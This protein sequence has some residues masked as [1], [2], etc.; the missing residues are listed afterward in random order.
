MS[1]SNAKKIFD[2]FFQNLKEFGDKLSKE[3]V[4]VA[5]ESLQI[6]FDDLKLMKKAAVEKKKEAERKQ[7][8]EDE[9]REKEEKIRK[10]NE[11]IK[12]VTCMDLPLDWNNPYNADERASGIYIESI[13]DALVKSLTTLGR[14]DIEFIASV[15]SSD[16]K[17]VITTLRGSIY[18]N[19]LTWNECFYHGWETSEEYLSGNLMEKLRVAKKANKKYNGYFKN[20][21]KAI[22]SVLPP[23]VATDDIYI[24]LGSPWVPSD[25]IDDF[26][27]HLFGEN[28]KYW[29]NSDRMKDYLSVKH[30]ELTGTWE[31]P[32][33]TR[34]GHGVTDTESYGTSRLE[35]LYILE[36]TLNMK[37]IAVKDEIACPTNASGKKR[38]IN[39]EET[40]LALEKQQKMI[41]EFQNWVWTD[42]KRKQRLETIFENQYSCVR[43][44]IF[45]GSFLDFPDLS[46][47]I[48]LFPY[49]KNAVARII[50]T[51]NTLL[52]HD[53]GSGKTYIMIASGMESRKNMDKPVA[54]RWDDHSQWEKFEEDSTLR[55]VW[56]KIFAECCEAIKVRDPSN[57]RGTLPMFAQRMLEKLKKPQTDWRTILNDFVQE[58][59]CD[60]SFS[61]PDRRFQD[62]PFFLPDFNEMGKNDNV[63][64]ILFF[65]DTSGSISDKDMTTAYSEI[66]GAIDQFGG[67][68]Q[69]WLGFFDAAIIEP[70]PFSSFDEFIAIK[71]AGG[72]GTD[73]QIIFEYVNRHLKEKKPN[74]III[75]TDG[76][77]PFP[78]EEIAN[79]IPVLWLINNED[80]T[81][82]WGKIARFTV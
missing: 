45:D 72:G 15:T 55:D 12:D 20:N 50:F 10:Q 24:T 49:Q 43:R 64:D 17:T 25:I 68:L 51:P 54:K 26:I 5:V 41:K 27:E 63:N 66:K 35:A 38:V 3:D 74:C 14:V 65:V 70:K 7:R 19:P 36:R 13:S 44:R 73:F 62:S 18:Q 67:K 78:K 57:K 79:N 82:P 23:T 46:P 80:V 16:Y 56:V 1:S 22:K 2:D 21:I 4:D 52:A 60:Y 47:N 61:P 76:Y 58:E 33:K 9:K 77:A 53:V 48:T 37:T 6:A 31:I 40:L 28:T 42:E 69:G 75:L 71:P 39:K 34:Y 32:Q 30:E 11:H 59:I 8:E 29:M 81:P